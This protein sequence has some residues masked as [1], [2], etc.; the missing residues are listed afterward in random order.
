MTLLFVDGFDHYAAADTLKKWTSGTNAAMS[1]GRLGVGQCAAWTTN[2]AGVSK[3]IPS[4]PATIIVGF[5]VNCTALDIGNG[6]LGLSDASNTRH[7]T[8]TMTAA[9]EINVYRGALAT[10]LGTTSGADLSAS[11]WNYIE[12]KATIHDTTGSVIVRVNNVAVLTLT[13]VDTRNAGTAVVG[14]ITTINRGTGITTYFDDLYVC[15]TA[16]SAPNNDFLGDCRV[17]TIYP[18]ADGA[19]SAFTP[20]TGSTHYTLVDESTPN[21]SDYND[22]AAV[23]DRDSYAFGDLSALTS[24]TVYG[25]QVNA[26]INKDDAGAKSAATFARSVSTNT[27]G[28][29]AALGTSQ[30]YLSQI[31]EQD[32]NAAAAWTEATVNAAEFG[33]KVTA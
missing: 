8:L 23:N 11:E 20:S 5:A 13:N 22:G 1:T 21:T 32:P 3:S 29:S 12:I 2:A 31:F 10:L 30:S 16:G 33:V 9:G 28:A 25:V 4:V 18:N 6:F 26:A 7:L 17:D 19:Y 24:Q 15:D 14:I 27:D